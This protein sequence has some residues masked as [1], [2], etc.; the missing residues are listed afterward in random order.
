MHLLLVTMLH[1]YLL[2]L[3]LLLP[4]LFLL[5]LW[6][7]IAAVAIEGEHSNV[8]SFCCHASMGSSAA[9]VDH[10][11]PRSDRASWRQC[12]PCTQ[13]SERRDVHMVVICNWACCHRVLYKIPRVLLAS[14]LLPRYCDCAQKTK[15][16][17]C[18]YSADKIYQ[19]DYNV[20]S[21]L[22]T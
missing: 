8:S 17:Q 11:G 22:A 16:A 19:A 3:L 1:Q 9:T 5:N 13:K 20:N 14:L 15:H 7:P 2:L 18:Q 12:A 10:S 4:H 21:L 6:L